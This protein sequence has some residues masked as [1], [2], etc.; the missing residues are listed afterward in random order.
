[1]S[2]IGADKYLADLV[3]DL[4]EAFS[5]FSNEAVKLSVLLAR[6]ED[7]V[8]AESC[9]ELQKQSI[10]EVQAGKKT[11]SQM[12]GRNLTVEYLNG[13]DAANEKVHERLKPSYGLPHFR[14]AHYPM[15]GFSS[16]GD[17]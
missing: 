14:G 11:S 9:Y 2:L 3:S 15:L 10:V 5:M 1:M 16:V 7:P 6:S 13:I 17:E 12:R 4:S 8:S